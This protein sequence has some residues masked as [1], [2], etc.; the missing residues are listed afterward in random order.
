MKRRRPPRIGCCTGT[1]GLLAA[2]A[3]LLLGLLLYPSGDDPLARPDAPRPAWPLYI[4]LGPRAGAGDIAPADP[5]AEI[6]QAP[7]QPMIVHLSDAQ[8]T[9]LVRLATNADLTATAQDGRL[10]VRG[11]SPDSLQA[12]AWLV[13][14]GGRLTVRLRSARWRD[15]PVPR[16]LLWLGDGQ[17]NA[18][19][20]DLVPLAE[21]AAIELGTGE[22]SLILRPRQEA[23]R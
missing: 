8:L 9:G 7:A 5:P 13:P 16:P 14:E 2:A 6:Y 21:V 23:G 19:L 17:A 10:L 12:D 4:D 18:A 15:V 3:F 11:R 22:T 1:L 20:A